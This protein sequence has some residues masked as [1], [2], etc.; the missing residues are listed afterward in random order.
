[1]TKPSA[2]TSP[3]EEWNK[4]IA[5]K[6]YGGPLTDPMAWLSDYE[7]QKWASELKQLQQSVYRQGVSTNELQK[8]KIAIGRKF[9]RLAQ[10][11]I[12][13]EKR[14]RGAGARVHQVVKANVSTFREWFAF[15]Y[16]K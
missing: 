11:R 3:Q 2:N 12:S 6:V 4:K 9:I 13:K 10:A 1:M 5:R 8:R 16:G 14:S 15:L 7:K